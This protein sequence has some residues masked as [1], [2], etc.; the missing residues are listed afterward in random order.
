MYMIMHLFT[1]KYLDD[2]LMALLEAGIEDTLVVSGEN[3]GAKISYDLPIFAGFRNLNS[4]K[5][6]GKLI[7]GTAEKKQVDFALEELEHSGIKLIDKKHAEIA[8]I[9]VEYIYRSE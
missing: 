3:M 7:I 4:A 8:L 9:P 6:Y 1:E 5:G 2:V